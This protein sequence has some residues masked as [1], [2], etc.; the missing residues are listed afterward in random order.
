MRSDQVSAV[1]AEA[2]CAESR[3]VR[4]LSSRMTGC[5][6]ARIDVISRNAGSPAAV[7]ASSAATAAACGS[8]SASA[9]PAPSKS[10]QSQRVVSS[11]AGQ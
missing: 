1:S 2:S 11:G 9:C 3:P 7:N 6:L 4:M 8:A 10:R 5:A